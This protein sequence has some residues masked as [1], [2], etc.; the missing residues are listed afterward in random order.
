MMYTGSESPLQKAAAINTFVT[1]GSRVLLMSLRSGA[2]VD[3]LQF[4]A[5]TVVYAELDWSPAVHD[6]ATGRVYRDGQT[7]P[8]VAYYLIADSGSDPIVV[9]ILGLK[10]IQ[11]EGLLNAPG[12]AL[13]A[14]FRAA[15]PG[16]I[17]KLA[18]A[19]LERQAARR[20]A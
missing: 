13:A 9:D 18:Q 4:A 1:G 8:V 3:G 19:Y 20:T 16:H 10:K 14:P 6:Q 17:K 5:R 12:G 2:G 15:D 11:H 7:D